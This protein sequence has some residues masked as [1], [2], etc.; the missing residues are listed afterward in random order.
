MSDETIR[1]FHTSRRMFVIRD[2]QPVLAP[3]GTTEGHAEWF[4]REGWILDEGDPAF[5]TLVRG[6]SNGKDI[7][8]YRGTAFVGDGIVEQ[9]MREHAGTLAR[10]LGLPDTARV[11]VGVKRGP[12][13]TPWPGALCLG[14]VI[15]C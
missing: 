7:Y 1:A 9:A 6:Y 13:G 15:A 3:I 8:A 11:F 5:A 12:E 14:Q 2:G 10:L 4:R